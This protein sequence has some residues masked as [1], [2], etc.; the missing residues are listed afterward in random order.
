MFPHT[1]KLSKRYYWETRK[2]N[3]KKEEHPGIYDDIIPQEIR[4]MN[5]NTWK[6]IAEMLGYPR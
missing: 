3:V 5:F 1:L 6:E 4:G 2:Q